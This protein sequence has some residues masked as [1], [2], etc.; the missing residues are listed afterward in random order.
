[1]ENDNIQLNVAI[2]STM[3]GKLGRVGEGNQWFGK[4]RGNNV[5]PNEITCNV[6]IGMYRNLGMNE[7]AKQWEE[8][9]GRYISG[10]KG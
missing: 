5:Q 2:Y 10:N 7:E 9:K 8:R 4:M 1:M 3:I 6:M